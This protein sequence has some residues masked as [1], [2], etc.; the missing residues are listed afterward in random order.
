LYFTLHPYG[1][2]EDTLTGFPDFDSS[3]AGTT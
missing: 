1:W 3:T 2:V